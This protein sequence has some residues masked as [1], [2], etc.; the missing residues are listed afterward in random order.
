M[1]FYI[2][3]NKLPFTFSN[4]NKVQWTSGPDAF[5]LAKSSCVRLNERGIQLYPDHW[6]IR[7]ITWQRIPCTV[8]ENALC[9]SPFGNVLSETETPSINPILKTFPFTDCSCTQ[10][11]T[12][13]IIN[14]TSDRYD[15]SVCNVM[16]QG[17]DLVYYQNTLYMQNT[18]MAWWEYML[19]CVL[20][21]YSIRTFSNIITNDPHINN[22]K[23]FLYIIISITCILVICIHNGTHMYISYEDLISYWYL[24]CYLLFDLT[25]FF[26]SHFYTKL[27]WFPSYNII[28]SSFVLISIRLYNSINTPYAPFLLWA[29]CTRFFIKLLTSS[30]TFLIYFSLF[31]DSLLIS[32]LLVFGCSYSP[33]VII[34]IVF[35][36]TITADIILHKKM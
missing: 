32:L 18:G 16:N 3:D 33:I 11:Y 34:C 12:N 35:I 15:I 4:G 5:A 25:V 9:A 22:N 10:E 17:G 8:K 6:N 14:Y 13:Q 2:L 23:S 31:M 24:V 36:A 27:P 19:L 26:I 7:D 21:I 28:I 30:W 1:P 20:C 29:I